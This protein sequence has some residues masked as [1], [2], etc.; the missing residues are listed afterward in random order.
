[1]TVY[2][3]PGADFRYPSSSARVCPCGSGVWQAGLNVASHYSGD[4]PAKHTIPGLWLRGTSRALIRR[5]SI[6]VD[7]PVLRRAWPSTWRMSSPTAGAPPLRGWIHSRSHLLAGI[8]HQMGTWF[9]GFSL[10]KRYG[11]ELLP[12]SISP[13]WAA[14]LNLA[15][16]YSPVP[17]GRVRRVH[18]PPIRSERDTHGLDLLDAIVHRE[19]H[20]P[21][22]FEVAFNQYWWDWMPAEAAFRDAYWQNHRVV[23]AEPDEKTLAVHIRRGDIGALRGTPSIDRRW[24]EADWF[25]TVALACIE[26]L[27]G[28]SGQLTKIV[29]CSQEFDSEVDR[30]LRPAGLPIEWNVEEDP[31]SA[32]DT[33]ASADVMVGSPSGFSQLAGMLNRGTAVMPT[34]Y[35]HNIPRDD[36]WLPAGPTGQLSRDLLPP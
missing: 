29:C 35:W 25:T 15:A 1:M 19:A 34:T 6:A 23:R 11:L 4:I 20:R 2:D 27:H 30:N 12:A 10:S 33:L 24:L 5:N 31:F 32:F 3:V 17:S 28:T 14:H 21:V 8:G 16:H 36:H 26:S 22:I 7:H 9:A 13:T 18:L